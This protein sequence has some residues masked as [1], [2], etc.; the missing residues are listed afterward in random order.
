MTRTCCIGEQLF[1]LAPEH[2]LNRLFTRLTVIAVPASFF[3]ASMHFWITPAVLIWA[4]RCHPGAYRRSRTVLGVATAAALIGFCAGTSTQRQV[5]CGSV[6]D[7]SD[8]AAIPVPDNPPTHGRK[9]SGSR[10]HRDTN[11][12]NTW[13]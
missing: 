10:P 7:A 13:L 6:A 2:D 11:R 3:S 1:G 4:H 5:D 9:P 12:R 8:Q